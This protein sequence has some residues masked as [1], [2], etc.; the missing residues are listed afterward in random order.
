M[1]NAVRG[2]YSELIVAPDGASLVAV[3]RGLKSKFYEPL[4]E[5]P[6]GY[7]AEAREILSVLV[8]PGMGT[9]DRPLTAFYPDDTTLLFELALRCSRADPSSWY[10]AAIDNPHDQLQLKVY[11]AGEVWFKL[12][13]DEDWEMGYEVLPTVGEAALRWPAAHLGIA[14][15]PRTAL[16]EHVLRDPSRIRLAQLIGVVDQAWD[17]Y[18]GALDRGIDAGDQL[19]HFARKGSLLLES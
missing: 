14:H 3:Q 7:V 15:P 18:R 6:V 12:G 8:R 16:V 17:T 4:A 11:V 2:E 1:V 19:L 10:L 13:D 5:I 9:P